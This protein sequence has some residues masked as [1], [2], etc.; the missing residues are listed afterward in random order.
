VALADTAIRTSHYANKDYQSIVNR[1]AH[2][3][4]YQIKHETDILFLRDDTIGSITLEEIDR[5][6]WLINEMNPALNFKLLLI[7]QPEHYRPIYHKKLVHRVYNVAA[8]PTYLNEC[9]PTMLGQ[10]Q[11][12]HT[13]DVS[14]TE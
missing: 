6:M 2:R 11:A 14:D 4:V 13:H 3:F 1:R 7:S 12:E 8:Y 5:F 9:F 10:S